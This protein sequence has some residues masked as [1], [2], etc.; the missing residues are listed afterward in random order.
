MPDRKADIFAG[1]GSLADKLRQNRNAVEAGDLESNAFQNA[2]DTADKKA[3]DKEQLDNARRGNQKGWQ[4]H[5]YGE[6]N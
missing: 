1:K 5:L 4:K 6:Q 3:S 2:Q